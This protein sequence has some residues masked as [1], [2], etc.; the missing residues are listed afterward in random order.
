MGFD[1]GTARTGY[2]V[3]EAAGTRCVY[4]D[5]GVIETPKGLP[6]PERLQMIHRATLKLLEKFQPD[7]VAVES[8]FFSKNITTAMTVAEARGVILLA[9]ADE[10]MRL[11]E[12]TPNQV[13]QAVTGNGAAGRFRFRGWFNAS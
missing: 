9:C 5:H 1:P 12:F 8:L 2:G 10:R 7:L 6:H 11:L 4:A 13:K 3:I